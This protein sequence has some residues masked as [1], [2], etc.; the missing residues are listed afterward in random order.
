[1]LSLGFI[2]SPLVSDLFDFDTT[3]RKQRRRQKRKRD[4]QDLR[5][6]RAGLT[7]F[8]FPRSFPLVFDFAVPTISRPSLASAIYLDMFRYLMDSG[9]ILFGSLVSFSFSFS[10]C[11]F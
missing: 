1:M 9:V 6:N 3:E 7:W 4:I 2:C 11:F 8:F 10:S 5:E